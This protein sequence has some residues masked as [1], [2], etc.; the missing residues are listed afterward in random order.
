MTR[1]GLAALLSRLAPGLDRLDE[2]WCVFGSAALMIRGAIDED[3]PDLDLFTTEAGAARLEAAW[4]H[5]RAE[6]Y[7]PDPDDPFLSRFSRY[8]LPEGAAEVMGGLRHRIG[9]V[10]T[11]LTVA[12]VDRV[13]FAGR[14][15]PAP[16]VAEHVRVLML[17][18]RP[19]DLERAAR[20]QAWAR[21]G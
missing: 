17:F 15:W 14:G 19:K 4:S 16:T 3:I 9:D 18:G 10:W 2:P 8:E 21:A 20:L 13:E 1:D 11:P 6:A 7:A 12:A 5:W